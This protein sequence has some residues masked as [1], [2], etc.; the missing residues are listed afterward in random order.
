MLGSR[1]DRSAEDR[2]WGQTFGLMLL[3]FQMGVTM[4]PAMALHKC[5]E[6]SGIDTC[7]TLILAGANTANLCMSCY[8]QKH[9]TCLKHLPGV[10][11]ELGIVYI[12]NPSCLRLTRAR[13]QEKSQ[14]SDQYVDSKSPISVVSA[15]HRTEEGQDTHS[16][17]QTVLGLQGPFY[18]GETE[19]PKDFYVPRPHVPAAEPSSLQASS[20]RGRW[21]P[22]RLFASTTN[23]S[24][25][26][27][28]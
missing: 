19:G 17:S 16:S 15:S 26:N 13:A 7:R 10:K 25:L 14:N 12:L 28:P 22:E 23:L 18:S 21:L 20:A 3:I 5:S 24:S 8:R 4:A 6:E 9:K 2:P 11:Q 1:G 27:S